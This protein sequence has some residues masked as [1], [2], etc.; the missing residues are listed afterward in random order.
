MDRASN[1][2]EHEALLAAP[3]DHFGRAD[4]GQAGGKAANLGELIRAGFPVP[5]GFV[6]TTTAY[7]QFVAHNGLREK[8][9][10]TLNKQENNGAAIR[11]AF[12][13][14]L[15]PPEVEQAVLEVYQVIKPHTVAVRSSATAEDLPEAAFAGQQDTY[16][17]VI[18]ADALWDAVRRCWASLWS[19]RA[20]AYRQRLGL[21]QQAV[22]IAVVVQRMAPAEAAGVL[23]TA[24]TVTGARDE[25]MI[26]ATPGLGEALVSGLVTADHFILR[27]QRRGWRIA[28][29]RAGRREVIVRP[30]SEG[31]VE[32]VEGQATADVPA[33]PDRALHQLANI[34]VVIQRHFGSPQDIEW[35]WAD[36]R[37]YILQARPI[38]ALPSPPPQA[39]RVVRLLA[40][41]FGEMLPVRPYPL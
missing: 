39:N 23:F 12:E 33:L 11:A 32:H 16:L 10:S 40:S 35:A 22:K 30:R 13:N 1:S 4:L 21:D 27:K 28:E 37:A 14:A 3:L 17:N 25:M 6:V 5:A 29:R 2:T 15:I 9:A 26:E 24:S 7:D 41:N 8:I 31:G 20:I 36:G 38:T 19:D 18:G 34:G